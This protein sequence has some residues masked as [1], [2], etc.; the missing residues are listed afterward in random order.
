MAC[1]GDRIMNP[2]TAVSAPETVIDITARLSRAAQRSNEP[3]CFCAT[4]LQQVEAAWSLVY[5]RY[6]QMGLIEENPYGIHAVPTAIGTHAC[7]LWGPEDANVGYTMTLFRDNPQGLAL[8]SVYA[9]ALNDLRRKGRRLMEV[10]MLADRRESAARG[11]A[12]LSLT[13]DGTHYFD[14]HHTANDTLDKIDPT[15]LASMT[16]P[17]CRLRTLPGAACRCST[18]LLTALSAVFC[19]LV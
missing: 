5:S 12:A 19:S 8:D 16:M 14:W 9:L 17:T 7:V 2:A 15:D 4:T 11:M 13:Q 1:P 18:V 10:G 3:A 6:S